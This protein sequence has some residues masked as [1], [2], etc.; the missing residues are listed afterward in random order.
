M[1]PQLPQHQVIGD[2]D[3]PRHRP[4]LLK[5]ILAGLG[6]GCAFGEALGR[7]DKVRQQGPLPCHL[8]VCRTHGPALPGPLQVVACYYDPLHGCLHSHHHRLQDRPQPHH[9]Q[10]RQ[11]FVVVPSALNRVQGPSNYHT[12]LHMGVPA[13]NLTITGHWIPQDLVD[14]ISTACARRRA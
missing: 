10:P 2:A 3:D 5:G 8:L 7:P 11:R 14:G 1:V 12:F 4:P 13:T 6:A 9:Q